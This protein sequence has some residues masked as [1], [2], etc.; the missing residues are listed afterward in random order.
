MFTVSLK[1]YLPA[2]HTAEGTFSGSSIASIGFPFSEA[3]ETLPFPERWCVV[4]A[5]SSYINVK[6]PFEIQQYKYD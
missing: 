5:N 1:I 6:R 3:N 4:P 2:F